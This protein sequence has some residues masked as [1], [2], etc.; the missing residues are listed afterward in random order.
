MTDALRTKVDE[1]LEAELRR[2]DEEREAM[3]RAI[4]EDGP[5]IA[6]TFSLTVYPE[7]KRPARCDQC[8]R[9][10]VDFDGCSRIECPQRTLHSS[11]AGWK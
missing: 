1:L 9:K 3:R 7:H 2:L 4:A 6:S 8:G 11:L 10:T 5:S